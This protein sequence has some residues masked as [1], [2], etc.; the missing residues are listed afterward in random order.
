[1]K[2]LVAACILTLS[3][4]SSAIAQQPLQTQYGADQRKAMGEKRKEAMEKKLAKLSPEKAAMV[5]KSREEMRAAN[6]PK[7]EEMDKLREEM[8]SLLKAEPFDKE[9]Y[10][11]KAKRMGDIRHELDL[12]R[13]ENMAATASKLTAEERA[14]LIER[15]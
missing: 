5:R 3:L 13:S 4:A 10:L 2:S 11:A 7:Y 15:R 12:K 9:A 6:R 8:R 14:I 1:M